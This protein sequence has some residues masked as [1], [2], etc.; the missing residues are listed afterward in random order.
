MKPSPRPYFEIAN[1]EIPNILQGSPRGLRVLD[2]GCGSGT[3]GAELL[4]L[5]GHRVVGVDLS[6]PSIEKAK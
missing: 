5:F 2:V 6:E 1:P 4:R 3:H